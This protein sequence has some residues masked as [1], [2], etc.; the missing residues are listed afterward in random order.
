M[1]ELIKQAFLHVDVIGPH[2]QEGHY[3][4][5]G[6]NG[7]IILP[8]VWEKVVEPDWAIAM[9]M[10]PMDKAPPLRSQMH[11]QHHPGMP[12]GARPRPTPHGV[13]QQHAQRPGMGGM[14]ATFMRPPTVRPGGNGMPIPPP[15]HGAAGFFPT[16]MMPGG[17]GIPA[18]VRIRQAMEPQIVQV[19]PQKPQKKRKDGGGGGGGSSMLGWMAGKPKSSGKNKYVGPGLME[20]YPPPPPPARPKQHRSHYTSYSFWRALPW[21]SD[22][23]HYPKF[24]EFLLVS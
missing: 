8:T 11:Q 14:A 2:V 15:P 4:L 5:I 18:G 17:P 22:P 10:W 6:P 21:Q 16:G 9:H 1:E 23:Y 20:V 24:V 12:H 3:D 19:D 7:E 13:H